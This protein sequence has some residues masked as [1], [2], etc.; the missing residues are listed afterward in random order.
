LATQLEG[1]EK[2]LGVRLAAENR[3]NEVAQQAALAHDQQKRIAQAISS[4][5]VADALAHGSESRELKLRQREAPHPPQP[6]GV[7]PLQ[8]LEFK[9]PPAR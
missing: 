2:A 6:L 3:A 9:F 8:P 4:A 1:I 7:P 5:D